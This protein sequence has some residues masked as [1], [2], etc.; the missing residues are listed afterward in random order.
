VL[1][2]VLDAGRALSGLDYQKVILRRLAFRGRMRALFD[3]I[4]LLLAPIHPFAPLSLKTMGTMGM[5]PKL[6]AR[7]QL[8]TA[9]ST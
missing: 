1:A 9:P 3:G 6:I 7:L 4:D 5:Q 2:A 8:Y